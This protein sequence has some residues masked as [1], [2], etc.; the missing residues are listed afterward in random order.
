MLTRKKSVGFTVAPENVY[1]N[2]ESPIQ[3][4]FIVAENCKDFLF[5]FIY[6]TVLGPYIEASRPYFEVGIFF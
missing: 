2:L 4:S 1:S 6:E 5:K 3:Q